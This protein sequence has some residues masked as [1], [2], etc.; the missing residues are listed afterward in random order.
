MNV[1]IGPSAPVPA[2]A[3][4]DPKPPFEELVDNT[5][6]SSLTK[7][8]SREW[9]RWLNKG[10]GWEFPDLANRILDGIEKGVPIDY[11]GDRRQ[12]RFGR[13]P[14][15]PDEYV[16]KVTAVIED[17]VRQLKKAG[18]FARQPFEF[19]A[20]S[21]VS[22]VPKKNSTKIRVVH[23]LSFPFHGDSVNESIVDEYLPLSSFGHAA[24]AVRELGKGCFLVKLDVEA[25]YKQVPVRREDWFLLGFMWKGKWY[26][27]R[28]LP[29]GL[30]SSCRLWEMFATAL[31]YFFAKSLNIPFHRIVVHY[32]DDFLFVVKIK[33]DAVR[34]RDGALRLCATLG[35]PMSEDKTEGPVTCLTFLGI[36]LDT[37]AMEARL[38]AA[39][40]LSLQQ[41]CRD[42][43]RKDHATIKEL[44]SL[45]GL[46]NF[47][48]Y[49]VR[50]GRFYLRRIIDHTV[51]I[52]R[53]AHSDKVPFPMDGAVCA[54]IQWWIDFLPTWKGH[55]LLYELEWQ[56]SER[57]EL[58]T[59]ACLTG[60]GGRF[61]QSFF[62]GRWSP[63]QLAAAMRDSRESMPFLELL[64]L[65]MAAAAWGEQWTAKKIT[66]RC[67]CQP[68]VQAISKGSSSSPHTMHLLRTLSS[69]ACKHG[70]DFQC[71]HIPGVSNRAADILSRAGDGPEFRAECPNAFPSPAQ[72]PSIPLLQC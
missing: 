12:S 54:D 39:R 33:D 44:Q 64:A 69:L 32:V 13:N 26:Y 27:E 7:M 63:A 31:H 38:P 49:V 36:E 68:V 3:R 62:Y 5:P 61:G 43:V 67:D 53:I 25:A 9:E 46:L 55:S 72:V 56:Q 22:A 2:A 59:D 20:V 60:Y 42:W 34:L 65:V 1:T 70:F 58:F 29:F 6:I 71:E 15:I 4:P 41:L 16:A 17:D 45:T 51:A 50:P 23:N 37:I 19:F 40:L 8:K 66:F 11:T 52:R 14:S 10:Y 18:P 30:R 35:I 28:V 21:P 47:A 24:R 48:C 57:I